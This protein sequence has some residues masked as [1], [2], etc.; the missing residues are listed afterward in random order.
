MATVHFAAVTGALLAAWMAVGWALVLLIELTRPLSRCS[1]GLLPD[2]V[3]NPEEFVETETTGLRVDRMGETDQNAKCLNA[4]PDHPARNF[5][6]RNQLLRALLD[7]LFFA[8]SFDLHR[9]V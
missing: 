7:I 6:D 9:V 4:R 2:S 5:N 1:S 3:G 8:E